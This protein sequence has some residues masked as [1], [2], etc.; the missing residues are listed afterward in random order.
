MLF[1]VSEVELEPAA[2][3]AARRVEVIVDARRRREVRALLAHRPGV[4]T[5]AGDRRAV[6][7]CVDA[8]QATGSG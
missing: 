4:S 2:D 8:L 7:R 5:A 6:R 3:G 1:I